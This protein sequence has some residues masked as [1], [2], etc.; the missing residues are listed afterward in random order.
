MRC[1][2]F[3]D[4]RHGERVALDGV[5]RNV[6]PQRG[7]GGAR[8]AAEGHHV[9]V[10]REDLAGARA[11]AGDAAAVGLEAVDGLAEAEVHAQAVRDLGEAAR[12]QVAVAGFVVGQA[13]AA[14]EAVARAGQAGF[15]ARQGVA[16][17]QFIGHAAFLE[18][19]DVALHR[20]ELRLRAKELQRAAGAVLVLQAGVGAQLLQAAAAVFGHAHHAFLVDR[21][22]LGRA[23]AQHGGHPAQ[24]EQRAV[25]ADRQRRVLLEHPLDRLQRNARC[26]PRR[27]VAGRHLA[28]VAEARFLG[29]AGLPVKQGDFGAG[30]REVVRR[31]GADHAAAENDDF[32]GVSADLNGMM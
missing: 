12:E 5:H 6:Q 3:V 31:G 20:V 18:H 29:R 14:R 24:L 22:A 17:E 9:A 4:Q 25:G 13:Q 19:G 7:D 23:V 10:G 15:D 8:V 27:R 28:G 1:Q 16:V 30:A 2:R 21:I 32:H 26:G 11:Y